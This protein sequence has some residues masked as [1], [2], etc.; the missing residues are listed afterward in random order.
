MKK[1]VYLLLFLI[2]SSSVITQA[3]TFKID[4]DDN[5]YSFLQRNQ[6]PATDTAEGGLNRKL[7]RISKVWGERLHPH[8]D[9]KI[10]ANAFYNYT[11][12]YNQATKVPDVGYEPN[13]T[14]MGPTG[15]PSGTNSAIGVGQIH[16][17]A[18][19]PRYD[20][21]T[22][23]TIYAASPF[24]GLWRSE[25]GGDDWADVNT[26]FLPIA[27]VSDIAINPLNHE[28]ILITTGNGDAG[29]AAA[30]APNT[31]TVNPIYTAG[32][33]RSTDYGETWEDINLGLLHH[34]QNG[35][36][37]RRIII[38]P[39]FP[40]HV[41]IASSEGVFLVRNVWTDPV[42]TKLF[43]GIG[44]KDPEFKGLEFM[45]GT[46]TTLYASG[47]DIYRS[48]DYGSN[49]E[50]LTGTGTGL[51]LDNLPNDFTINR[52]NIAVTPAE[53][54]A[55]FAYIQGQEDN[56]RQVSYIYKYANNTW[57]QLDY[58]STNRTT[59]TR[60]AIAV[61]PIDP[62]IIYY[63]EI[64]TKGTYD[65]SNFL[66]LSP[67]SGNGYHADVHALEFDPVNP[68]TVFCGHD[69]GV[70]TKDIQVQN[71]GGWTFKNGGLQVAT[72]WT[73][74]DAELDTS[75]IV[76]GHQDCGIN[77]IRNQNGQESW[78]NIQGGDGYGTR[79][80]NEDM[81]NIFYKTSSNDIFRYN[82][83]VQNTYWEFSLHPYDL[84]N[85][86]ERS[87]FPVTFPMENHPQTQD[88]YWGF[89]EIY[90]RNHASSAGFGSSNWDELWEGISNIGTYEPAQWKRQ[91]TEYAISESNP[92]YQ[93]IATLGTDNGANGIWQLSPK[94]FRTTVGGCP[95]DVYATSC[96]DEI[97]SNLPFSSYGN[98]AHPIITD[99]VVHPTNPSTLWVTFTGFD[100]GIKVWKSTNAGNT[101]QNADPFGDLANM[102]VNAIVYSD[103]TEEVD[104][105]YIGTDVGIFTQKNGGKWERY[106]NDFPNVRVT[107]LKINYC[108]GK[109]RAATFGRGLWEGDLN[110]QTGYSNYRNVETDTTWSSK[111]YVEKNLRI[112]NGTDLTLTGN[113]YVLPKAK[114]AVEN[115]ATL[116]LDGSIIT[117]CNSCADLHFDVD[118]N[119]I[120]DNTVLNLL[121][122]SSIN[123]SS[124]GSVHFM[125]DSGLCFNKGT[126]INI[127]NGGQIFFNGENYTSTFTNN[128]QNDYDLSLTTPTITGNHY[129]FNS[130]QA[131]GNVRSSG[132]TDLVAG[133]YIDLK[134]IFT[135]KHGLEARIETAF[136][137][138][139]EGDPCEEDTNNRGYR[140]GLGK[141]GATE[142]VVIFPTNTLEDKSIGQTKV[143]PSLVNP[144][145]EIK[146]YPNPN[147]GRFNLQLLEDGLATDKGTYKVVITNAMGQQILVQSN[148]SALLEID[149]VDA[150]KG[151][152]FITVYEE[153]SGMKV[154]ETLYVQ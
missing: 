136:N 141:Q 76:T 112:T 58:N 75:M 69:G 32:V 123:I 50:S 131:S 57:T 85:P 16:A 139:P 80:N 151:I 147:E 33:Y 121:G 15:N 88:M 18:F 115:N 11:K 12:Q 59:Y 62:D 153:T 143:D 67:P 142:D 119:L 120:V 37:I 46:M 89:T 84:V 124:T 2:C 70:S 138:C 117:Y 64:Y 22:N 87:M 28:A 10:A 78:Q 8:G 107:E 3:Q 6:Q 21:S 60:L 94:L 65:G 20:G 148:Q 48:V 25:N 49:W 44:S 39:E 29:I 145:L 1:L 7:Q 66:T 102:P 98:T 61:S 144:L 110:Y 125:D 41:L 133:R 118:G 38:N 97:T 34:F 137:N 17:L 26:D 134:H 68:T 113:L 63:G 140:A 54:D 105:L 146:A 55:L 51:E 132:T 43:D 74:D 19:D 103:D 82:Y 4:P 90:K 35:G 53:S 92:D 40:H 71:S 150:P 106:G 9:F 154:G 77:I 99:I 30:F 116:T 86:S 101:W 56:D 114:I 130:I 122:A 135:G 129:A 36:S 96:F 73:F 108:A 111:H 31:T 45:P 149:I 93:Y 13:W 126:E 127:A 47:R 52:I 104:R 95:N 5:F 23:Q 109:L 100:P 72:L 91:I 27:S 14:C 42:W 24:G 152:Y 128:Y 81:N 83:D 79:I